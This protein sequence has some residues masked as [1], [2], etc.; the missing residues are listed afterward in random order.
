MELY[1][2]A[3]NPGVNR[4]RASLNRRGPFRSAAALIIID[5]SAAEKYNK[6]KK[7][8]GTIGTIEDQSD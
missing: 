3:G 7:T 4:R 5:R 1:H 6:T 2:K 8:V